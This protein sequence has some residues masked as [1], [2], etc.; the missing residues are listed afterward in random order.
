MA[1]SEW[2]YGYG[3]PARWPEPRQD[4]IWPGYLGGEYPAGRGQQASRRGWTCPG[5]RRGL[6]PDV[7]ECPHCQ[8]QADAC[9]P[10]AE[11]GMCSCDE[12]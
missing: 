12:P 9:Q 6:H 4:W 10:P 11:G 1:A 3:M 5:C 8:P 2:P 7:R